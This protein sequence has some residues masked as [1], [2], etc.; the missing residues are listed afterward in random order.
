MTHIFFC[1]LLFITNSLIRSSLVFQLRFCVHFMVHLN[2]LMARYSLKS[3]RIIWAFHWLPS[4]S[5]ALTV[6]RCTYFESILTLFVFCT[7]N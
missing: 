4:E 7:N 5:A 6:F 2:V 3:S 1:I